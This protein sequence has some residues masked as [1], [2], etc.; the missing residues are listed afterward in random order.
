MDDAVTNVTRDMENVNMS[1]ISRPYD[2]I[3]LNGEPQNP[4][5]FDAPKIDRGCRET[6]LV[7][8]SVED[9]HVQC[10][11]VLFRNDLKTLSLAYWSVPHKEPIKTI[12]GYVQICHVLRRCASD[13]SDSESE[14]END[15]EIED[16][17]ILFQDDDIVFQLT[18]QYVAVKVNNCKTM[19]SLRNKHAEDPLKEIAAMQWIGNDHPHVMGCLDVL[20]DGEN[21]NINI[22]MPFCT[23]GD[24]F[25]LLQVHQRSSSPGMEESKARSIFRQLVSGIQHLQSKGICHRDMSPENIM[26]NDSGGVIIDMGMSLRIPYLDVPTGAVVDITKGQRKLLIAPQGACGKLPYMAPEIYANSLRNDK[27]PFDGEAV[28]IWSSGTILFCMLTGNRS[29]HRAHSSD[30]Q[31]YWMTRDIE[32]LLKDWNLKLTPEAI[33]F[34]K[35]ML[36]ENPRERMTLK[37]ILN[38]P[39]LQQT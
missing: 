35:G 8:H 30:A 36:Q 6:V 27:T 7:W 10:D 34:L 25:G 13:E 4:I 5:S 3:K 1:E 32:R 9:E 12:M 23:H 15:S 17:D 19:K 16:D 26:L 24:L 18:D 2:V 29:Y 22:V 20:Y 39:W 14:S 28:D 38:H 31:Y 11:N 21:D 33:N 37:E